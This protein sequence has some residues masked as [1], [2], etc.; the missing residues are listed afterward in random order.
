MRF[1]ISSNSMQVILVAVLLAVLGEVSYGNSQEL[2][3]HEVHHL[4]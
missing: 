4:G 3:L 2:S 1:K